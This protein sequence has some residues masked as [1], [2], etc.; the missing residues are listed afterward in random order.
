MISVTLNDI[1]EASQRIRPQAITSPLLSFNRE[2]DSLSVSLKCESFQSIGAFKI[3]GAMNAVRQ[4][5][6]R[7]RQNGV[8]THSSGNHA[9][10]L[11]YAARELGIQAHIVMPDNSPEIKVQ[12]V[13]RYHGIVH[14]CESSESAR[15]ATCEEVMR[16]TSATLI[17]PFDNDQI[18]SGQ[19]T[20][21]LEILEQLPS[22]KTIIAPIGGGGLISGL[23]IAIKE[24]RS[25]V[26]LIGVEPEGAADTKRSLAAGRIEAVPGGSKSIAEGLLSTVGRRPFEIISKY[27]DDLIT[28]SD[29]QIAEATMLLFNDGKLV[30]EP[31]GATAFAAVLA[32]RDKWSSPDTVVMI[33][34]GNIDV[35]RFPEIQSLATSGK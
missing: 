24:Q 1:Q 28:V 34:G 7:E 18:I 10:A 27:L 14:F 26:R 6:E 33:T 31:S 9:Q 32:D 8:V 25:D 11:A 4:L 2:E 19:G 35:R 30:V 29:R 3:R 13:R 20:A 22:V 15:I 23:A 5:S 12:G 17:H 16:Q 21:G